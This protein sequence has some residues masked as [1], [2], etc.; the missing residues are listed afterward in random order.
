MIDQA[1]IVAAG[2][3]SLESDQRPD[4]ETQNVPHHNPR[5]Q[6]LATHPLPF[7]VQVWQLLPVVTG[8]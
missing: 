6:A 1:G 4:A 3:K 2:D 8:L 7:E 5:Q